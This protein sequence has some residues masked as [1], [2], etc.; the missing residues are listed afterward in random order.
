MD[1]MGKLSLDRVVDKVM[2]QKTVRK[3][4]WIGGFD[5]FLY[6]LSLVSDVENQGV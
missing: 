3:N 1:V 6:H 5:A 2:T 4:T